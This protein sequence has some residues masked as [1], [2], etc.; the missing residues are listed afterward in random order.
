MSFKW[1]FHNMIYVILLFIMPWFKKLAHE[2][3]EPLTLSSWNFVH[4][5]SNPW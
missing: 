1:Y 5:G 4:P 3:L 2:I